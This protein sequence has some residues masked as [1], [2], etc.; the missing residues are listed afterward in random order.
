MQR[1]EAHREL[2]LLFSALAQKQDT[3]LYQQFAKINHIDTATYKQLGKR[4]GKKM[5]LE[6]QMA[7]LVFERKYSNEGRVTLDARKHTI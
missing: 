4:G 2:T 1:K 6:Q 3:T 5:V 7:T